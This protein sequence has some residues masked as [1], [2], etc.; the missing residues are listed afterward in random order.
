MP[1]PDLEDAL[2]TRLAAMPAGLT[3]AQ[4]ARALR[5]SPLEAE[6]LL[7]PLVKRGEVERVAPARRGAPPRFRVPGI[8]A[9][10]LDLRAATRA[11]ERATDR[12]RAPLARLEAELERLAAVRERL[13]TF[14]APLAQ[15]DLRH[16]VAGAI[17]SH[18]EAARSGGLVPLPALRRALSDVPRE[19]LDRALLEMERAYEIELQIAQDPSRL[20]DPAAAL[21]VPGRGLL[22]F[23]SLRRAAGGL[24]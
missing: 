15:E 8:E 12:V 4:C 3:A 14:D 6:S 23:A 18:L 7:A 9:L 20:T 19:S 11:L 17:A 2:L 5:L 10:R 13:A 16:R 21:Q 22:Y 1:T 24:R